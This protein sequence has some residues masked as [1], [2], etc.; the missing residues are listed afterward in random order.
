MAE[1]T[2]CAFFYHRHLLPYPIEQLEQ[3]QA[4]C[5]GDYLNS[6]DCRVRLASFHPTQVG[7]I[8][9]TLLTKF[10]LAQARI[11]A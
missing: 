5:I 7:L 9:A 6:I 2:V 3:C 10:D 1:L 11:Q 4:K 8:E